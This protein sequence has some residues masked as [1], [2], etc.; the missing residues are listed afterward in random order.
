MTC[1]LG[2]LR[3][4]GGFALALSLL[5]VCEC[6]TVKPGKTYHFLAITGVAEC[7]RCVNPWLLSS[8]CGVDIKTRSLVIVAFLS[9][10]VTRNR[11]FG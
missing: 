4:A 11:E 8:D 5:L 3:L 9:C 2:A 1:L 6:D 7:G 10:A